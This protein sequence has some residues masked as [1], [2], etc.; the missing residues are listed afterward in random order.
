[1]HLA[2]AKEAKHDV[3]DGE[4]Y[5]DGCPAADPFYR[6]KII[7]DAHRRYTEH[8]EDFPKGLV[9]RPHA[10]LRLCRGACAS[11]LLTSDHEI[12]RYGSAVST[13]PSRFAP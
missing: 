13:T 12:A 5:E 10:A 1:M 8:D 2:K 6:D 4:Y 7:D 9:S 11:L 3:K